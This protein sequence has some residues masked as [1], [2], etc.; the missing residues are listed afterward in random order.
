MYNSPVNEKLPLSQLGV[1]LVDSL[2]QIEAYEKAA[3]QRRERNTIH[4]QTVGSTLSTAYE[5]L[6]NASEYAEDELLQQRAIRR[7][8]KRE[9]SFHAKV[10]TSQLAQE[11][12]TELTQA[13][14]LENDH[15]TQ[16]DIKS[17]EQSIS[18]YYEAYWKFAENEHRPARRQI[19]QKWLLDVLAVRCEQVLRSHMRQLMFAHFAFRY[20]QDKMPVKKLRRKGE[21]IPTD[22]FPIVLYTAIHRSILKSDTMTIRAALLDSYQVPVEDIDRFYEFNKKLDQLFSASTTVFTARAVSKNGAALRFIYSSFFA[23]DAPLNSQDLKTT[24]TLDLGLRKHI[25]KEYIA[26]DKRLDKGIMRSIIFLFITKS[27]IGLGIEVPYDLIVYG[28]IIWVPLLLNLFFPSIFIAFTRLTLTTP[29]VRNTSAL[30]N[31]I[32]AMLFQDNQPQAYPVRI[33][34]DSSSTSFNIAYLLMFMLVFTGLVYILS[35]LHFNLVQ[36]AI[37]FIFLSTASF[38]AF[39]LSRQIHELEV[40]HAAQNSLSV[41]RDIIYMPFIYVGQQISYRYSQVN[42]IAN[43]LDILIELPLKTILRLVRQWVQFLN[44]KKDELL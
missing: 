16:S 42:I 1:A 33:P 13:E 18:V 12:V 8:L 7:Y 23:D 10:P 35:L 37:F 6:R 21:K 41:F 19:F 28:S 17:I 43:A 36:G 4:V 29:S 22:D 38:L 24:S 20:L 31:Q 11:L 14:Y 44:A 26:L 40:V 27:V 15:V 39:R 34:K 9:L 3:Q 30:I 5:Q 25:E 32:T 2:R